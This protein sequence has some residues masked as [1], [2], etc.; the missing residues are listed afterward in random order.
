MCFAI[1]VRVDGLWRAAVSCDGDSLWMRSAVSC[2][3]D[4]LW[5]CFAMACGGD[6]WW[7]RPVVVRDLEYIC[8]QTFSGVDRFRFT[9]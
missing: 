2:D 1:E 8:L 3:R 6:S 4:S 7:M 9:R 5:M